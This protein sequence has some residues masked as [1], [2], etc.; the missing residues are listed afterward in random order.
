M[1]YEVITSTNEILIEPLLFTTLV[2]NAFKHGI[3]YTKESTIKIHLDIKDKELNF[4]VSNPMVQAK[5]GKTAD[6]EDAGIG[7]NNIKKRLQLLYPGRHR[8]MIVEKDSIYS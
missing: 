8:L 1:L 4:Y 3:D 5:R 6:I 2:E 7:L